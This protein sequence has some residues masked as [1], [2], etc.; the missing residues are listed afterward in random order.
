LNPH[1]PYGAQDF[2]SFIRI[3][4]NAV[5]AIFINKLILALFWVLLGFIGWFW[6]PAGKVMGKVANNEYQI[7]FWLALSLIMALIVE[8]RCGDE[9]A[10]GKRGAEGIEVIAVQFAGQQKCPLIT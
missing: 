9:G 1:A 4:L 2:K 8:I 7:S 10:T 5:S 3:P 6:V